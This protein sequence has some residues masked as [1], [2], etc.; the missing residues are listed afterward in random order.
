MSLAEE[1]IFLYGP[2]GSGKSALGKLMA[3]CL[4]LTFT[5]LDVEIVKQSGMTISEI[6]S[7]QGEDGFRQIEKSVLNRVLERKGQV[8]ALGG[9]ALLDVENRQQVEKRGKV[10]CL[11][12]SLDQ[13]L[14]RLAR[15]PGS[16][17]LLAGEMRDRLRELI[18]ARADHYASFS[19]RVDTD[20]KSL[21]EIAW[22]VQV[23]LGQ[24]HVGGM[25]A[26]YDVRVHPGGLRLIGEKLA[27]LGFGGRVAVVS[28]ANVAEIYGGQV[29][30]A[31]RGVGFMPELMTIPAGEQ[32]KNLQTVVILW[33]NF[34][35]FGMERHNPVIALGG[36]VTGDLAGFA[37]ATCL[38]G[39]PWV[40]LPTSLLAMVDASLGG[41]T[42]FDLA[43]G[44][45]LVGAFYPPR[46]VLAD[47][48]TLRSLPMREM[49]AG[50]A[51]VL[52][53]GIIADPTLFDICTKGW[54]A[55]REYMED[56]IC[57]AMAVKVCL[58]Q[59]DPYEKDARAALNLGHTVGHAL[60]MASGYR[61]SHGEAVSVGLHL[62]ARLA[63]AL[64]VAEKGLAREI[65]VILRSLGMP[66]RVPAGIRSEA[67]LDGMRVDKKKVDGN[68]HFTLPVKIG[69]VLVGVRVGGSDLVILRK[70]LE[71]EI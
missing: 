12:A 68:L 66:D 64:G 31:L 46:L 22:Q 65:S 39:M 13:L 21:D 56:I 58:I 48:L 10:V 69:K 49:R 2:S 51:E 60:E 16:R 4:N 67:V 35:N 30:E 43:Q 62:E 38:R 54:E 25:G 63:E 41:K 44:K 1:I 3:K 47:P 20:G 45:N 11:S 36:G 9:G 15:E 26:G 19:I 8:V 61:L 28:D 71:D 29:C 14:L 59:A 42:G 55:V 27:N 52:K 53:A 23:K 34:L 7:Q 33:E 5:D 70:V 57:R 18:T 24:F 32:Y 37:A 50:M 40:A 17:P 6:F